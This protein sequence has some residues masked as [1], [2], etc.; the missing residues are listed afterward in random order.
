MRIVPKLILGY[1]LTIDIENSIA[2]I[3]TDKQD[4]PV[5]NIR[6]IST[7]MIKR[8]SYTPVI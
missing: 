6:I 3:K 2:A 1:F 5:K 8:K 4:K 7:K